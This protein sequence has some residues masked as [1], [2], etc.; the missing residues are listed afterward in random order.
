MDK[1][2][3][4]ILLFAFLQKCGMFQFDALAVDARANASQVE[5]LRTGYVKSPH[6]DVTRLGYGFGGIPS[7]FNS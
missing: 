4:I 6:Q 7:V 5:H 3:E 1:N 2:S